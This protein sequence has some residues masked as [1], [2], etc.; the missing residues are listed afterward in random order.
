MSTIAGRRT[1]DL[2]VHLPPAGG[3]RAHGH[4]DSGAPLALG[5]ATLTIGDLPLVGT[6]TDS[7]LD[8]P[9]RPM[10]VIDGGAGWNRLLPAPD[11]LDGPDIVDGTARTADDGVGV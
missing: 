9:E 4:L 3:W 10:F 2:H 7:Y 8:E 5:A 6:V 1:T 11:A